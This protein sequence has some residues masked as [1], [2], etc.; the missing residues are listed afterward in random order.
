MSKHTRYAEGT[1]VPVEQSRLEIERTLERY[2][3]NGFGYAW[4]ERI[5]ITPARCKQGG[6]QRAGRAIDECRRLHRWE[7]DEEKR[8][9]REIVAISFRFKERRIRLDVPMPT[10]AEAG[11]KARH[12]AATRQR[13]RA[14]LLVLK[15]KLEAVASGISTLEHEFLADIVTDSGQTV[16]DILVPRLTDAV[17]AGRL[18]PPAQEA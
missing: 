14:L 7:V 9:V 18:L 1:S 2:E 13:W 15:A 6:C 11:S 8:F 16:G 5:E 17:R 12:E 4:D 10:E 3:A